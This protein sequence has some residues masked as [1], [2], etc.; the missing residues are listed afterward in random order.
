MDLKTGSLTHIRDSY[1]G[2]AWCVTASTMVIND[3]LTPV[4]YV[5]CEDG[6]IKIFQYGTKELE[7]YKSF[8]VS[9]TRIL[10]I[11]TANS[12]TNKVVSNSVYIG[13]ADGLIKCI[14]KTTGK[15]H[16]HI[17]GD[18]SKGAPIEALL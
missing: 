17:S 2:S 14:D 8:P 9:S 5:G 16:Y 11:A 10:C 18:I 7:Y 15:T 12:T 1:G 13:T 3:V 6:T 4:L